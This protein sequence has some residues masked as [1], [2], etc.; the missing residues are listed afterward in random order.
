MDMKV[1]MD[2]AGRIVIPKR[3]RKQFGLR[4]GQNLELKVEDDGIKLIPLA[5]DAPRLEVKDGVLALAGCCDIPDDF[6]DQMR[7]A[8]L[9]DLLHLP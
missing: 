3:V 6:V 4:G 5:D 2:A 9:N 7:E 8:R 1:A